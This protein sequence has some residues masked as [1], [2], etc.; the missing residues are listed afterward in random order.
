M[1]TFRKYTEMPANNQCA[2]NF[3]LG[4]ELHMNPT[5]QQSHVNI[6]N[7]N[8]SNSEVKSSSHAICSVSPLFDTS[9]NQILTLDADC[10]KNTAAYPG[11]PSCPETPLVSEAQG[12]FNTLHRVGYTH[13][14]IR[15]NCH[16]QAGTNRSHTSDKLL[17]SSSTTG[18]L[19]NKSLPFLQTVP[20]F[21]YI[22]NPNNQLTNHSKDTCLPKNLSTDEPIEHVK[23]INQK[24]EH[25]L[26]NSHIVCQN[27]CAHSPS[28]P[29]CECNKRRQEDCDISD[30]LFNGRHSTT[31]YPN[32]Q[33]QCPAHSQLHTAQEYSLKEYLPEQGVKLKCDSL[34]SSSANYESGE[35]LASGFS[36]SVKYMKCCHRLTMTLVCLLIFACLCYRI[37]DYFNRYEAM[38]S[39][40]VYN[41]FSLPPEE[42]T[43]THNHSDA[44]K[45][46]AKSFTEEKK[47]SDWFTITLCNLNPIR[48]SA[49]FTV[50]NGSQIYD[51]ISKDRQNEMDSSVN[52]IRQTGGNNRV[53]I[54][55]LKQT[56]HKLNEMLKYCYTGTERCTFHNFTS[57]L[58]IYGQC[59]RMKLKRTVHEVSFMLDSQDYDYIIPH[60]GLIGF[61]LWIHSSEQQAHNMLDVKEN[62]WRGNGGN[63][64]QLYQRTGIESNEIIVSTEFQTVIRVAL[65]MNVRFRQNSLKR[66]LCSPMIQS[67]DCEYD[68]DET[69]RK[70]DSF[71]LSNDNY[72]RF[73]NARIISATQS[74]K[75]TIMYSLL[76]LRH[77]NLFM[78]NK[79]DLERGLRI[80]QRAYVQLANETAFNELRN[81]VSSYEELRNQLGSIKQLLREIEIGFWRDQREALQMTHTDATCSKMVIKYFETLIN[82]TQTF[83]DDLCR[84]SLVEAF[85]TTSSFHCPNYNHSMHSPIIKEYPSQLNMTKAYPFPSPHTHLSS[86]LKANSPQTSNITPPLYDHQINNGDKSF[87]EIIKNPALIELQV[88]ELFFSNATYNSKLKDILRKYLKLL[89]AKRMQMTTRTNNNRFGMTLGSHSPPSASSSSSSSSSSSLTSSSS[90][91]QSSS[92]SAAS[93][94]SSSPSVSSAASVQHSLQFLER[95]GSQGLTSDGSSEFLCSSQIQIHIDSI[96]N[97]KLEKLGESIATCIQRLEVFQTSMNFIIQWN[98]HIINTFSIDYQQSQRLDA[99]SLVTFTVQIE[100]T[101]AGFSMTQFTPMNKLFS[102]FGEIMGICFGTLSLLIPLYL[103]VDYFF[104]MKCKNSTDTHSKSVA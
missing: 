20:H 14:R 87:Y 92:T 31:Y 53:P 61:R 67:S 33:Y 42:F 102:P 15:T 25:I 76:A 58:T 16:S 99:T 36:N 28:S 62:L 65:D 101:N 52:I 69:S 3:D 40:F 7:L 88:V 2:Q 9:V 79:I 85:Y 38:K 71:W 96:Y 6:M 32:S 86:L 24:C 84:L 4:C 1:K 5:N 57:V 78:R 44:F 82:I 11:I 63:E 48:G 35:R 75:A 83:Q 27:L 51:M 59:Y 89:S 10:Y 45:S 66:T 37:I 93:L 34:A 39:L 12:L 29:M 50:Q 72:H 43:D 18:R 22:S 97:L 56:G 80:Q 23:V 98:K 64:S 103:L 19:Q 8:L 41:K 54:E 47:S 55:I 30:I 70:E 60:N 77:P 49:L 90:S 26:E 68:S 13:P 100:S 46:M 74:S 91:L 21:I 17:T 104:T 73:W 81:L 95:G 94:I